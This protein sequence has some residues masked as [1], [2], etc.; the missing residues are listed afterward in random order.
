[1]MLRVPNIGYFELTDYI[2][3]EKKVR[4]FN[5]LSTIEGDFSYSF[6]IPKTKPNID[7]IKV[8]SNGSNRWNRRIDAVIE[9]NTGAAIYVG[10]LRIEGDNDK[11]Y[12]ASFFSG[13]SDW[14]DILNVP[15]N[16]L[17]WS[18]L[19]SQYTQSV[20]VGTW[21][22]SSGMVFP[23]VDRGAL[24]TR[25]DSTI[26]PIDLQ[27]MLYMKD[28]VRLAL[29]KNGIKLEGTIL[30]DPLF[31]SIITTNNSLKV[32]NEKLKNNE[33][34]AAIP[35]FND[36]ISQLVYAKLDFSDI[37]TEPNYNSPNNNYSTANRRYTFTDTFVQT[38]IEYNITIVDV[39]DTVLRVRLNGTTT[40]W[41]K[42]FNNTNIISGTI[43]PSELPVFS[44]GDYLEV[45][46]IINSGSTITTIV[47]AESYVLYKPKRFLKI[48]ASHYLTS[49]TAT[50]FISDIF[51]NL[52]CFVNYNG[53][54]KVLTVDTFNSILSGESVNLTS[55]LTKVNDEFVELSS[56]YSK[57]NWMNYTAQS[58]DIVSS[59]N[60]ENEIPYGSGYIDVDNDF[61]EDQS[62][63][64]D[65][66]FVAPFQYF[67][68]AFRNDLLSLNYD[69]VV[70]G[71]T[72]V[73]ITSITND[74]GVARF[75]HATLVVPFR[76]GTL[77][78][79]SDAGNKRYNGEYTV[80]SSTTSW[81]TLENKSYL[82]ATTAKA[83]SISVEDEDND[84]QVI[85]INN[86]GVN[87]PVVS[88]LPSVNMGGINY[89]NVSVATFL[90]T[91]YSLCDLS[92]SNIKNLYWNGI[93]QILSKSVIDTFDCVGMNS[94]E[95]KN[96]GNIKKIV[97]DGDG[98]F[99]I[100]SI[101]GYVDSK[102]A[103]EVKMVKVG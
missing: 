35:W 23:L 40:V 44:Q 12:T 48:E 76:V 38:E 65:S 29:S 39:I 54:T 10:F 67:N 101:T 52:N 83:L 27:P 96:I 92:F 6:V 16:S 28:V 99:L 43:I 3:V 63:L 69:I 25:S 14:I 56:T 9:D 4:L 100:N 32:V 85:A 13:N 22:K 46:M 75:N 55:K 78:R 87:L 70:D 42:N 17:N 93:P 103:A 95:F 94:F 41:L 68:S 49:Q 82:S 37:V 88:S 84:E 30:N 47:L 19:D 53:F 97:V 20:M 80:R 81:F 73:D 11:E 71:D 64:F 51:R 77:V 36:S 66:I 33:V 5:D 89:T 79:I 91:R 34:R 86:V 24:L 31:N 2:T 58:S 98:V 60:S 102:I 15:L 50:Q 18:M 1:M 57:R 90:R 62:T 26:Y 21:S 74:S 7:I 61:L 59:Y 8:Y 72:V 45:E